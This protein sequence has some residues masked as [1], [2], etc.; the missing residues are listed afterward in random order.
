[1]YTLGEPKPHVK[2]YLD[3]CMGPEGQKIVESIGYVPNQ[4]K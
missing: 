2:A 1:M 4:Q 3:W